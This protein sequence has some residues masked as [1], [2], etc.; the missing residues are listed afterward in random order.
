MALLD[1]TVGFFSNKKTYLV[2]V[3]MVIVGL[4]EGNNDM[5]LQGLG[6]ICLRLGISKL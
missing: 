1:K 6:L 4:Y 5:V 3:S 2:G